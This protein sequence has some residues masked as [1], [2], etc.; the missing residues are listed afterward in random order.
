M[1]RQHYGLVTFATLMILLA[2]GSLFKVYALTLHD[3]H[4]ATLYNEP[5]AGVAFKDFDPYLALDQHP[6]SGHHAVPLRKRKVWSSPAFKK[7]V[8][9]G[10]NI[11]AALDGGGSQK[12][13]PNF[14]KVSDLR[15]WGWTSTDMDKEAIK[16]KLGN[17]VA[18]LEAKGFSID[19]PTMRGVTLVHARKTEHGGV[20]YPV[21]D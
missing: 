8:K 10:Q 4:T 21:S 11:L 3:A 17:F 2:C 13:R 18:V 9:T 1:R 19:A 14:E 12:P 15:D 5:K 16:H 20:K 7:A 6:S